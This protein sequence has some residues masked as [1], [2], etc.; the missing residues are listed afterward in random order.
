[1]PIGR[2]IPGYDYNLNAKN[3]HPENIK[4]IKNLNP[5]IPLYK[6]INSHIIIKRLS[7]F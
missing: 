2:D 3:F 5:K 4:K 1:M 6:Y 7:E